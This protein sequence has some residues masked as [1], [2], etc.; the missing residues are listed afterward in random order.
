MSVE[1]VVFRQL[2]QFVDDPDTGWSLG[3]FG[4]LAEF[5]REQCEPAIRTVGPERTE[6]RTD[7]GA[8]R[9]LDHPQARIIPYEILSRFDNAW[10]QGVMICLPEHCCRMAGHTVITDLGT[11]GSAIHPDLRDL[12]MFDLGLGVTHM[13]FCIGTDDNDLIGV[14]QAATGRNFLSDPASL[15][16]VIIATN[17]VRLCRSRVGQIEVYQPIPVANGDEETPD[18]PHTHLLPALLTH[19]RTHTAN[20]PIPP[21]WRPAVAAYP[22]N[23]TR[24]PDGSLRTFDR[25]AFAA[26]QF[27]IESFAPDPI[28]AIK[29]NV[30]RAIEQGN[31]PKS[32]RP[33]TGRQERTALRVAL[34]QCHHLYGPSDTLAAWKTVYEPTGRQ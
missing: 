14:L 26:F 9:L 3:T 11:F 1:R 33:P 17:P 29:R 22:P 23:P 34:R 30:F 4:A 16:D 32:V 8:V 25:S 20:I 15:T 31:P 6:L 7:R 21:G 2:Q 5:S 18:G 13:D 19:N 28:R 12:R 27:L 24:A 10:S